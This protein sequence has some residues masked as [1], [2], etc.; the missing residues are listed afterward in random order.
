MGDTFLNVLFIVVVVAVFIVRTIL[1]AKKKKEPPPKVVIP[2]H[3][4]DDREPEPVIKKTQAAIQK[5]PVKKAPFFEA[6]PLDPA[7]ELPL[8]GQAQNKKKTPDAAASKSG[9]AR[10]PVIPQ[11]PQ[12]S[13]LN[14]D[15]L[16]QL[17]QA[18]VMA[19][20]LGPPKGLS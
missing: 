18:V 16:S 13:P 7:I 5:K 15:H 10:A 19:E 12:R 20:I 17:K 3:F 6:L 2:V 4:E 1:G 11:A 9:A 14:L 8:S